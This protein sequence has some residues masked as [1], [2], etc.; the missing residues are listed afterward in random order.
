[1]FRVPLCQVHIIFV[2]LY[3]DSLRI[4]ENLLLFDVWMQR[5]YYYITIILHNFNLIRVSGS[6]QVLIMEL[7][8]F[9]IYY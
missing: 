4:E 2:I 9:T 3:Y 8:P 1:M 5:K 6:Y 7:F